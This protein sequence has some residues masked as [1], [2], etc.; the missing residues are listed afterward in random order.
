M[1]THVLIFESFVICIN[2]VKVVNVYW[3]IYDKVYICTRFFI[4]K[5]FFLREPQVFLV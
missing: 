3:T 5:Q 2:G 4:R 1:K